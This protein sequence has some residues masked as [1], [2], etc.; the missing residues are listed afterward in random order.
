[1][2]TLA[3][4]LIAALA[5]DDIADILS[6]GQAA[7]EGLFERFRGWCH[8][9]CPVLGKLSECRYCQTFW[10]SVAIVSAWTVAPSMVEV[11]VMVFAMHRLSQLYGEIF[12][13]LINRDDGAEARDLYEII[14]NGEKVASNGGEL[15]YSQVVMLAY[16]KH[17]DGMTITY[18]KAAGEKHEGILSQ[19]QSVKIKDGT[20][21]DVVNTGSA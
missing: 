5:A 12:D 9:L 15:S 20:R 1:M 4:L 6:G 21:F 3:Y 18:D 11:V 10:I 16:G 8:R 13:R 7:N 14:V 2:N 17:I 19:G